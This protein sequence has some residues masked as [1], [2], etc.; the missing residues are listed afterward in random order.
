[1]KRKQHKH[2]KRWAM[3]DFFEGKVKLNEIDK[4]AKEYEK[5][6]NDFEKKFK[7]NYLK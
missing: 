5:T 2:S 7:V 3:L 6:A 1:M 4:R